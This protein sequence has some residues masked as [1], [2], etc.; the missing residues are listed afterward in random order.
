MHNAGMP[1]VTIRNVP[2]DVHAALVARAEAAGQSLQGYLQGLLA[3]A[4]ARLPVGQFA[5]E[6][7]AAAQRR[8]LEGSGVGTDVDTVAVIRQ[9]RERAGAG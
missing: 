3:S 2:D 5:A 1:N 8:E 4:A 6:L 7:V 9:S